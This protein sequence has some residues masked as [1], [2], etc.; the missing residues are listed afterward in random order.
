MRIKVF[1]ASDFGMNFVVI[2]VI[3]QIKMLV[4]AIIPSNKKYLT[5]LLFL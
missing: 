2:N 3:I 5:V 4:A 1:V